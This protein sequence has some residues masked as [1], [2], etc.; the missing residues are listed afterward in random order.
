MH[1]YV[2]TW[3][4]AWIHCSVFVY[5]VTALEKCKYVGIV[6]TWHRVMNL[7][8]KLWL[9]IVPH[10][11]LTGLWSP[12]LTPSWLV[13]DR[14]TSHPADPSVIAPPHTRLIMTGL[15]LTH[16]TVIPSYTLCILRLF[17]HQNMYPMHVLYR[18]LSGTFSH[19]DWVDAWVWALQHVHAVNDVC[20][21]SP[22]L[23]YNTCTV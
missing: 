15:W 6:G 10:T 8:H 17:L 5:V 21:R 13:C 23:S 3:Q 16:L 4:V 20:L 11:Q 19:V 12:H 9:V 1:I 22:F 2:R 18:H 14:P 7:F